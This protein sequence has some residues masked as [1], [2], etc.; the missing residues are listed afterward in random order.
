MV[1]VLESLLLRHRGGVLWDTL[2]TGSADS[3]ADTG[4]RSATL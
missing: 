1:D 3:D 2:R 4:S